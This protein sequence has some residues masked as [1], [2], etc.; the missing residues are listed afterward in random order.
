[1][2]LPFHEYY[3]KHCDLAG[4]KSLNTIV[5]PS[6]IAFGS[7]GAVISYT[8]LTQKGGASPVTAEAQETR[9][10]KKEGGAWKLAHFH[11]SV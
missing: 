5:N 1:M 3:F 6:V 7:E 4:S 10:W 8:R 9:V 11:K 2:Q